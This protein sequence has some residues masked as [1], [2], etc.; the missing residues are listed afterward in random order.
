M[1]E[2]VGEQLKNAREARKLS[3]EQ[4]FQAIRINPRYLK[5]LEDDMRSALP[6]SVQG[7]GFLR[8]Y[9]AFLNL[10]V[11]E[12][13]DQW[14]GKLAP[15]PA[16]EPEVPAL[17]VEENPAVLPEALVEELPQSETPQPE[18]PIVVQYVDDPSDGQSAP[19]PAPETA[20]AASQAIFIE[21]GQQLRERREMLGLSLVDVEHFTRLRQHY[22]RA[23]EAGRMD[24]LPSLVQGRGMLNNYASFLELNGDAILL[25]FAEALQT[26]RIEMMPAEA[27]SPTGPAPRR[28]VAKFVS[29]RAWTRLVTPD[30][31]IGGLVLLGI[32]GFVIWGAAQVSALR[33]SQ[34]EPTAPAIANVL[35]VS[36]TPAGSVTPTGTP[37]P[38]VPLDSEV[39]NVAE[40]PAADI[41]P[42][43][44]PVIGDAPLQVYVVARQRAWMQVTADG[45]VQFTGRVIPGNAYPFSGEQQIE[46]VSGDAAALQIFYNQQ[47]LGALGLNGQVVSLIFNADGIVTP[48][49]SASATPT[50]TIEPTAT[51]RATQTPVT[52][53]V[54][55]FIP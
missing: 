33:A 6:S 3:L 25:R 12:L 10:P 38:S 1:P 7:K 27:P 37:P 51:L 32:L 42:T 36:P 16:P 4:V 39:G 21:I 9:A 41:T 46:L 55:P 50:P 52:P 47:D 22:L 35:A 14:E 18:A 15:T 43:G 40:E 24:D 49:P 20:V 26:R 8:L 2:T 19:A 13:V 44:L 11:Q 30:L 54:T 34:T 23:M 29:S 28:R 17:V 5:G 48:T 45:K 53:T 31:L